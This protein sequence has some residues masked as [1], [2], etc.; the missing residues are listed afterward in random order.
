VSK[1][2]NVKKHINYEFDWSYINI[3]KLEGELEEVKKLGA[4]NISVFV[5]QDYDD[6]YLVIECFSQREETD[7]EFT[8][9]KEKE[10][11]AKKY[12]IER[13]LITLK[14]LKEKYE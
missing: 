3:N 6:S 12:R 11:S 1:K 10:E 13:D 14:M 5:E 4:T 8:L 7:A 9:R 2:R